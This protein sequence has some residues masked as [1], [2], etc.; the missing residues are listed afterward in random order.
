LFSRIGFFGRNPAPT[1]FFFEIKRCPQLN[2][3]G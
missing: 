3:M 2:P 1:T